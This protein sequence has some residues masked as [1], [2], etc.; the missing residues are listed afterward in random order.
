M[1]LIH[2]YSL[3]VDFLSC[4]WPQVLP[5]SKAAWSEQKM[6]ARFVS[7]IFRSIQLQASCS[8]WLVTTFYMVLT[9]AV[10]SAAS[11]FGVAM[12]LPLQLTHLISQEAILRAQTGTSRWCLWQQP[13]LSFQELSLSGLSYGLSSALLFY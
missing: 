11:A 13:P 4:L 3:C 9:K 1:Y 12:T 10:I 7:R 5:C 8:I 6:S 2:C